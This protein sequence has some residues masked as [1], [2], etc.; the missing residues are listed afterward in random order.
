MPRK[1]FN[2]IRYFFCA[3]A[4]IAITTCT[5]ENVDDLRE[6]AEGIRYTVSFDTDGG[7]FVP[8]QRVKDGE[9]VN[10]PAEPTKT[11]FN[12]AG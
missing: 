1:Y 6:R 3:A 9:T 11:G 8:K 7:S 5:L 4:L 2:V 10:I 12:F